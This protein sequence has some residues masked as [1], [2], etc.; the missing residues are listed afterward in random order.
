MWGNKE[1][2]LALGTI[3]DCIE[4]NLKYSHWKKETSKLH[5]NMQK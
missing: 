2:Q 1:K 3:A 4:I 5:Y